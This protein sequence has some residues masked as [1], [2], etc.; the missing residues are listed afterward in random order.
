MKTFLST[1]RR[2]FKRLRRMALMVMLLLLIV[3]AGLLLALRYWV[4]PDIG[5]YHGDITAAASHAIGQPV[6]IGK[7]EADW[8]GIRPRLLF[9]DVRILDKQGQTALALPSV[10]NVLSWM[11]L[12][13]GEVRL[14]SLE[15]D[16]PDL[17]VKRDAQGMLH[18]AGVALSSQLAG[19]SASDWLLHQS[20]IMVRNA[21]ITWLDERRAAPPLVLNQV[22]LRLENSG[23]R[24]SFALRAQPPAQ[25]S[26]Q[27]DVRGDFHGASFDDFNVWSGQLFTQLDYTDIAAW[28]PWLSLPA[29]LKRGRG[30]VRGWV[31]AEEGKVV[32]VTADLSLADVQTQLADDLPPLDMPTLRGR[33]AWHDGAQNFEVSTRKLSLR[34]KDGLL[35]RPTDFY[36]RLDKA[37]DGQAGDGYLGSG[38]MRANTLELLSLVRLTNFLPLQPDLKQQLADFSPRGLVSNLQAKWQMS[39]G[40]LLHYDIKARFD[41]ISLQRVGKIPGFSGFS[42]EVDGSDASGKLSLNARKL[43]VDSPQLLMEPLAF[44]TLAAQLGWQSKER[45]VEVKFDHISVANEDVAGNSFGS[46]QTDPQGRGVIDL[47]VHLTRASVR[48][49]A[50]Y[51]PLGLLGEG[52][53]GWIREAL[54]DGQADEF[55]LRLNGDLKDFPFDGN[56]KGIFEIRARAKDVA[57]EYAKGWPRLEKGVATLLIQGKRIEVNAPTAMTAGGQVKDVSVV[58]PDIT[59]PDLLLQVRG[60]AAGETRYCLDF[61]RHSPVRGYIGGMTDNMTAS[62]NG[63]LALQVNVPLRGSTPLTVSGSY[64]FFENDVKMGEGFPPLMRTSGTLMFTESSLSTRNVTAQILGGPTALSVQSGAG[65]VVQIKASGRADMD[66]LR[67]VMSHPLLSYLHGGS[68]WE[69]EITT[70]GKQTD[71]LFTSSLTGLTSDLPAPFA[72]QA[73]VSMPLRLEKKSLN[74]QQA[75]LSVQLGNLLDMKLLS[76]EN[77]GNFSIKRGMVSLGK[78]G[79]WPTRDGVWISGSVPMLSLAGWGTLI[80]GSNAGQNDKHVPI[81]IAGIN[82]LIKKI[83]GYGYAADNLRINARN[84]KGVLVAQLASKAINGEVK[85]Q[86]QGNGKLIARVK[87]FTPYKD[88]IEKAN[89][90]EEVGVGKT[91]EEKTGTIKAEHES[92]NK[93]EVASKPK[94]PATT[95]PALDLTIDNLALGANN[96]GRLELLAQQHERDWLLERASL[97]NPDGV[98]TAD[99]KWQMGNEEKMQANVKLEISNAGNI[100]ARSGY[101]NTVKRGSG[102]LEGA[103]SWVG[104]PSDFSYAKLDGTLKLD[105]GKGQFLK[106]D[107]GAGKL[108]SILSLQS[109]PQHV[110]LDFADVFSKGFAFDS[111]TGAAQINQG[112]LATNDLKVNGSAAKVTMLGQVDLDQET[113]NLRIRVIPAVGNSVSLLSFAAGPIVGIGVSIANQILSDPLGKLVSFEYNV[114]GSWAE[115]NVVKVDRDKPAAS[116]K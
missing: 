108:L 110:S 85:W 109:L 102:K 4:L 89:Q 99:G 34:M 16:Q 84:N 80:G 72:K 68:S 67:Q 71:A 22:N 36:L 17:L 76:V 86:A 12:L 35:L 37:S 38:E 93:S 47:T 65:G 20:L 104:G 95:F 40:K 53:H 30:A 10:D 8:R 2:G 62:G 116:P 73:G 114:T 87:N 39:A 56:S 58:L 14:Y 29:A 66:A 13:A 113:Q 51:I 15:L 41:R 21:R 24:H 112:V 1:V 50:R 61:I 46:Y 91:G 52:A 77:E 111:I 83:G 97:T 74:V 92:S 82:L 28:R 7:I 100:L 115:P 18:I 6:I 75:M 64:L 54:Q 43:T 98:L 107:P 11:T 48:H 60:E 31:G 9:T 96:L 103:F 25:L 27:L 42:G 26:T 94:T 55:S 23:S 44:D 19:S 70:H 101:P 69:A 57:L 59:S 63:N 33:V 45:G 79:K 81:T 32:Q 106:I 78:P 5:R 90:V 88:S 3:A 49:T 105:T